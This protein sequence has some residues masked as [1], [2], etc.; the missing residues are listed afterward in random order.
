MKH[1]LTF[2]LALFSMTSFGYTTWKK[3]NPHEVCSTKIGL[4]FMAMVNTGGG[5]ENHRFDR[6]FISCEEKDGKV[7]LKMNLFHKSNNNMEAAM[8]LK[9]RL[10]LP[11]SFCQKKPDLIEFNEK[12]TLSIIDKCRNDL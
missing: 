3:I 12:R 9:R 8:Y 11:L 5:F 1:L 4:K 7:I 6:E 2:S 10:K